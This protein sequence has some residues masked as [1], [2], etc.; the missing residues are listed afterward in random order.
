MGLLDSVSGFFEDRVLGEF[1]KLEDSDIYGPGPLLLLYRVPDGILDEEVYDMLADGAPTASKQGCKVYRIQIEDTLLSHTL[2]DAL[3]TIVTGESVAPS[4]KTDAVE[5]NTTLQQT[6]SIPVVLFSGFRN[7]EMMQAYNII[8]QEI[9]EETGGRQTPACAKVVPN[10][11]GK[12][13][14]QVLD[15][16]AGDHA[17]ALGISSST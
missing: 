8:G 13:L 17:D 6:Q 15:E 11:M 3:N 5:N 1:L 2:E 12:P 9:N 16:I 7:D 14:Q 10:A 4:Q